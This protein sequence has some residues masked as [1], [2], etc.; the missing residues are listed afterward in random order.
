MMVT[1]A[2]Y[3]QGRTAATGRGP[4]LWDGTDTLAA[5]VTLA[6]LLSFF[7][8][9]ELRWAVHGIVQ[10]LLAFTAYWLVRRTLAMGR[11][12]DRGAA[13]LLAALHLAGLGA[14]LTGLLTALGVV[15][16][17]FSYEMGRIFTT[18]Q[19]A[20][21]A[22]AYLAAVS[23][24]GLGWWASAGGGSSPDGE[25]WH[26]PLVTALWALTS[27]LILVSMFGTESLGGMLVYFIVVPL[28]LIGLRPGVRA[29]A[30]TRWLLVV[31][32]S[33]VTT[34]PVLRAGTTGRRSEA[35]LFLLGGYAAVIIGEAMSG[36]VLGRAIRRP[37]RR[38][39]VCGL[40]AVVL[41]ALAAGFLGDGVAPE[42][43]VE[44]TSE[45]LDDP[46]SPGYVGTKLRNGTERLYFYHDAL[47]MI[48]DHPIVGLGGGGWR[49]AFKAYRSY[50]YT[51]NHV[52][53]YPLKVWVETGSLG[54]LAL[55]AVWAYF[56][57]SGWLLARRPGRGERSTLAWAGLAT[58]VALGFHAVIDFDINFGAYSMTI[59]ALFGCLA[60]LAQ[61]N[62][63]LQPGRGAAA[64]AGRRRSGRGVLLVMT[65]LAVS[66]ITLL[67]SFR[68]GALYAARATAAMDAGRPGEA[69]EWS[70]KA[71]AFDP[72][73]GRYYASLAQYYTMLGH[74]A[75]ARRAWGRAVVLDRFN[76]DYR[77]ELVPYYL[78]DGDPA[79]AV[80]AME[81]LVRLNPMDLRVYQ[82]VSRVYVLAGLAALKGGD[83]AAAEGY[84]QGAVGVPGRIES[85]A[86]GLTSRERAQW[87]EVP[88]LAPDDIVRV[89]AA[90]GRYFLGD[91][92]DLSHSLTAIATGQDVQVAGEAYLWLA[93]LAEREGRSRDAEEALSRAR[94]LA[95]GTAA[96][97]DELKD[98]PLLSA[99]AGIPHKVDR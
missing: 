3:L 39:L 81:T 68:S 75:E 4:I 49:A 12:P 84:F 8:A 46:A 64:G 70:R 34:G 59:Y 9:V 40:V 33:V 90:I 37:G 38:W 67:S 45:S 65:L 44:P 66:V 53:S 86:A 48:G 23:I 71:V 72:L 16:F 99:P 52:H 20:N 97:Y 76:T 93:I 54:F 19:Y 62:P 29:G 55:S 89:N 57:R 1:V 22:A 83:R 78:E 15:R 63:G 14:A 7:F 58:L 31:A 5:A 92:K 13:A 47:R 73:A 56:L 26:R 43:E 30:V 50:Y 61:D 80:R 60:A 32:V 2:Y 98:L 36:G 6:Y 88:M 85:Q 41:L 51:S 24:P 74:R 94:R 69:V 95:P 18:F 96:R 21:T 17:S 77:G 35:L 28:F 10:N 11:D 25:P 42:V 91:W 27:Y 87:R 79:G 82:G